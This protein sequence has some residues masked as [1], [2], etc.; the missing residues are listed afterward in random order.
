MLFLTVAVTWLAVFLTIVT[1]WLAVFFIASA[2]G[3]II[4][5]LV[6]LNFVPTVGVETPKLYVS[7]WVIPLSKLVV[8]PKTVCPIFDSTVVPYVGIPIS[9]FPA[10][11]TVLI[12]SAVFIIASILFG[13]P[14]IESSITPEVVG[15]LLVIICSVVVTV[16]KTLEL[17]VG[18]VLVVPKVFPKNEPVVVGASTPIVVVPNLLIVGFSILKI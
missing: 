5:I 1:A 14:I 17:V 7:F 8:F 4:L 2:T 10:F 18:S 12:V 11:S 9:I 6:L 15:S 3:F 16:S 13:L